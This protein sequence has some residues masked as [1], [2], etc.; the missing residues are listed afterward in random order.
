MKSTTESGS[1]IDPKELPL[2]FCPACG[3]EIPETD[4]ECLRCSR[5]PFL[6]LA[7]LAQGYRESAAL[8]RKRLRELRQAVEKAED[9]EELW[10]LKRRIAELTPMLTQMNELAELTEHYYDRGYWRNEKYTL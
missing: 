2:A 8:L 7:A 6:P 10:H 1:Y 9:P 5:R 4:G 3:R